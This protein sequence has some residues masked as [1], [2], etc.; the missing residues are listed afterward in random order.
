MTHSRVT[1]AFF[2]FVVFLVFF[3]VLLFLDFSS[4]V[5]HCWQQYQSLTQDVSSVVS[6]PWRCGVLTTW[7]GTAGFGLGH[8]LRRT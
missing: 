6:A 3:F 2:F 5:F 4:N 7:S 8:P 1:S